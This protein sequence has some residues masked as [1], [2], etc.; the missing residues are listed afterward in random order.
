MNKYTAMQRKEDV[1][2][3]WVHYD[4]DGAILGRLAAEIADRKS[5]V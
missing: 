2:R 4:A 5:V 1:V 3:D